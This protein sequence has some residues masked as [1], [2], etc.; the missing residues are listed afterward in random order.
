MSKTCLV[1]R[2]TLRALDWHRQGVLQTLKAIDYTGIEEKEGG[3][4]S[5]GGKALK[6]S[7]GSFRFW[8]LFCY[9]VD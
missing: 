6:N 4:R 8:M 5:P 3:E 2:I 7:A 9:Y 1:K